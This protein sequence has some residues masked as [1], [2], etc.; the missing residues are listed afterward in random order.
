MKA[1]AGP[2]AKTGDIERMAAA[3]DS[4]AT[5]APH[6][7]AYPN[8][9]SIA[10]DGAG[11]ARRGRVDAARVAC[12]SCHEQYRSR[13]QKDL[14]DLPLHAIADAGAIDGGGKP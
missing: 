14:R 6:V 1:N 13:F 10:K 3:F 11:V 5:F 8:W 9:V 4:I 2:P 7:S 12:V